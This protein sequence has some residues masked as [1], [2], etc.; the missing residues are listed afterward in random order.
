VP[1]FYYIQFQ[2]KTERK[3]YIID[4][5]GESMPIKPSRRED[6]YFARQEFDRRKKIEE[7]KHQ[8]LNL[9]KKAELKDL[10]WMCCPKCGMKLIE[11]NYKGIKIDRCSCCQG[12][13]LDSGELEE[14]IEMEKS[15]LN[16]LFSIFS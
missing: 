11:I 5:K 13:W 1:V 10:H 8:K 4:S 7:E 12:I 14:I 16:K 15:A 3:L 2:E 6:E 9:V